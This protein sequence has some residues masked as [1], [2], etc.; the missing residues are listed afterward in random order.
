MCTHYYSKLHQI[1][2]MRLW[3]IIT[4]VYCCYLMYV[5]GVHK[6]KFTIT[7]SYDELAI[8]GEES[9]AVKKCKLG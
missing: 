4:M 3:E 2:K 9:T 5:S 1:S 7:L 8:L 6:L